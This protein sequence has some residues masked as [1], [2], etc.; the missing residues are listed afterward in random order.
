MRYIKPISF[1]I[2]LLC[3]L[4]SCSMFNAPVDAYTLSSQSDV[5]NSHSGSGLNQSDSESQDDVDNTENKIKLWTM[6]VYMAGDNDLEEESFSDIREMCSSGFDSS[7]LNLIVLQ[8]TKSMGSAL[9]SIEEDE[10]GNLSA[11]NICGL[12]DLEH[13]ID[14]GS[15]ETLGKALSVT[16][17]TYPSEHFGIVIWGHEV[18]DNYFDSH[19][20]PYEIVGPGNNNSTISVSGVRAIA[21]DESSKTC[22]GIDVLAKTI[23]RVFSKKIDFIGFDT[24]FGMELENVYEVRDC[25]SYFMGCAGVELSSGWNYESWLSKF[26]ENKEDP[27]A[28][29]C[30]LKSQFENMK[31]NTFS[32]IDLGKVEPLTVAFNEYTKCAAEKITNRTRSRQVRNVLVDR[33]KIYCTSSSSNDQFIDVAGLVTQ[34]AQVF[35]SLEPKSEQV[36][37]CIKEAM[38]ED[39]VLGIQLPCNGIQNMNL[40]LF[41]VCD[42]YS[43]GISGSL[44]SKL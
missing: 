11:K 2:L 35:P 29:V 43:Y 27:Y 32:V 7:S 28:F 6:F 34:L 41:R 40:E 3:S 20:N 21:L 36:I 24:C 44:M 1:C 23:K 4:C 12:M 14:M 30:S 25:A 19:K 22:M 9:Y 39:Y 26:D 5:D 8:D 13:G 15:A 18:N 10:K 42:G 38:G 37:E 33:T 16:K 31:G 17:E